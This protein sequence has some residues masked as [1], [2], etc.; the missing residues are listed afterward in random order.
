MCVHVCLQNPHCDSGGNVEKGVC[1]IM[2]SAIRKLLEETA[3][4][5]SR[6]GPPHEAVNRAHLCSLTAR[7]HGS[8][9]N[10]SH[11]RE[12][13][14]LRVYFVVARSLTSTQHQVGKTFSLKALFALRQT[15]RFKT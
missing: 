2:P 1:L 11:L 5:P 3:V 12:F 9:I 15:E 6:P 14:L 8:L 4:F 10:I 7:G 13:V